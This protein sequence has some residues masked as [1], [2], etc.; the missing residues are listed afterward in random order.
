MTT[1]GRLADNRE[2]GTT[3]FSPHGLKTLCNTLPAVCER[4]HR[5]LEDLPK[6]R[7][8]SEVQVEN[9]LK[10]FNGRGRLVGQ[11]LDEVGAGLVPSGLDGIV[12]ELLDAI[13]NLLIDLSPRQC[14][15]DARCGLGRVATEEV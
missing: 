7:D 2:S 8:E 11:D 6:T 13:G 10:P 5:N 15:I 1:R 12:V 3:C 14:S 4:G 9:I